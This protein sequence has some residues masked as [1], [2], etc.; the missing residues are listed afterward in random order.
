MEKTKLGLPVGLFGAFAIAAVG[1]GGYVATAL[2]VGY[3]LLTEENTWLK[4]A[5]VKAA[6][7]MVFFD[8]IIALVGIIPDA[9]DWVVS[10]INTFGADIY[11]NFVSDI[12]NLVCRVLSIC[13]D[14]IFLGLNIKALNQGT[15]SIPVV[16]VIDDKN[17]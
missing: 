4:K 8:F 12:F 1:F 9:A 14:I 5:V 3:V 17:M 10:L 11:G 6:A 15:I 16:D 2:V 13:E 7:T